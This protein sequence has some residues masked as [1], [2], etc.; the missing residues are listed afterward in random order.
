LISCTLE[1]GEARVC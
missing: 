1:D